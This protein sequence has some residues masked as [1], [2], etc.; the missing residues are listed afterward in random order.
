M[1]AARHKGGAAPTAQHAGEHHHHAPASTGTE[2][3][4]DVKTLRSK[5]EK[6]LQALEKDFAGIRGGKADPGV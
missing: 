3:L 1:P 4:L 2:Q 5:M 6:V